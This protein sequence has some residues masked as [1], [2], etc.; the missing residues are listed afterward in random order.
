[1]KTKIFKIIIMLAVSL[2]LCASASWAHEKKGGRHTPLGNAYGYH[3]HQN[4]PDHHPGWHQEH[5]KSCPYRHR[6]KYRYHKRDA[7]NSAFIF[8]LS[9]F[10]PNMT[11]IFGTKGH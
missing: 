3:M 9:F 5:Y 7:P 8:G 4:E 6:P 10:D 1:M 11:L 2:F